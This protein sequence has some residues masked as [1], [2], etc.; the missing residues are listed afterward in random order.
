MKN[1]KIYEVRRVGLPETNSSSSHSV[2]IDSGSSKDSLPG[3]P[4]WDLP[5]DDKGYI[6]IPSRDFGREGER[7]NT[8]LGKVQYVAG[9]M[10]SSDFRTY[11]KRL[12]SLADIL[13]EISGAKDV[14]FDWFPS[15]YKDIQEDNFYVEDGI[16]WSLGCNIDH[17]SMDL[18]EE[19]LEST[20]I[21]KN[22]LFKSSSWLFLGDDSFDDDGPKIEAGVMEKHE[23]EAFITVDVGGDIGRVDIPVD[24][25]PF[26]ASPEEYL[27]TGWFGDELILQSIYFVDGKPQNLPDTCSRVLE[28]KGSLKGGYVY[29]ASQAFSDALIQKL[30]E[31][32]GKTTNQTK[33]KLS[34]GGPSDDE[35]VLI[36]ELEKE[37]PEDVMIIPYNIETKEF[38]E[39]PRC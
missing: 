17:Q 6:H 36:R 19:V 30:S 12:R 15:T 38:G 8:V 23:P 14:I 7:H 25:F 3:S 24:R 37:M 28:Y 2:V 10:L 5:I 4:Y 35:G 18:D 11:C 20:E 26:D 27:R 33:F 13:V 39:V 21:L 34:F 31:R 22:F 32:T 1:N 9:L 16:W 29:W